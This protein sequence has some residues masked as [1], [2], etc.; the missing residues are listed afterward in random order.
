[1]NIRNW[2]VSALAVAAIGA[3]LFFLLHTPTENASQMA[4]NVSEALGLRAGE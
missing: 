3:S 4:A 1:M 2:S